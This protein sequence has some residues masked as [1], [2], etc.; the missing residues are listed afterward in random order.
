MSQRLSA[1]L[2]RVPLNVFLAV[3]WMMLSDSLTLQSFVVGYA[4]GYFLLWFLPAPFIAAERIPPGKLVLLAY[5]LVYFI[6]ELI[7]ANFQVAWQ[8]VQPRLNIKPGIIAMPLQVQGNIQIAALAN[9]I[10]L[11]PGTLSVE[12]PPDRKVL[13]IHCIDASDEAAALA[14]PRR[15]EALIQGVWHP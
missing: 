2:R 1:P 10:S 13:Y 12:V 4:A 11:T 3:V 5:L 8:V 14:V 6:K 15:F 9:M 7:V